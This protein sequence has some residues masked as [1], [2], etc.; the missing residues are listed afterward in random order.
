ME[1]NS[2]SVN[3]TVL[4]WISISAN[5]GFDELDVLIPRSRN[6]FFDCPSIQNP[7]PVRCGYCGGVR[8]QHPL[9]RPPAL[10]RGQGRDMTVLAGTVFWS[11]LEQ[12]GVH[13]RGGRAK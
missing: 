9:Q 3:K 10:P 5:A 6:Y 1:S 11:S 8:A 7:G 12:S 2:F 4:T 13:V